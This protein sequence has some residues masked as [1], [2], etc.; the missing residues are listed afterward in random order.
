[1]L[2]DGNDLAEFLQ[3]FDDHDDLFAKLGAEQ[4]HFNEVAILVPVADDET[5][6]GPLQCQAG[7]QFWF[8]AHFQAEVE[9]LT[10]VQNFFHDFTELVHLDREN[11]TVFTLVAKLGDGIAEG[12]VDGFH[13]MAKDVLETNKQRESQSAPGCLFDHIGEVHRNAALLQR[14]GHDVTGFVDVEVF[15]TPAVNIVKI[16]RRRDIPRRAGVGRIAHRMCC[17]SS[18]L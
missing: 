10:G 2:G 4:R 11:A 13:A 15:R 3:L 14:R 9:R 5:S 16:A 8:A 18:A 17:K 6:H 1:L 12:E 7:E